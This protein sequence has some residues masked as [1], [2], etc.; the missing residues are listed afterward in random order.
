MTEY[1]QIFSTVDSDAAAGRIAAELVERRLAACVQIVP[2]LRSV[3]WWQGKVEEAEEY[4]LLIKS[5]E[6][7]YPALEAAVRELHPYA[8]PELVGLK[9]AAGLPAY[10]DW[11]GNEV[12]E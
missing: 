7:Q 6:K 5:T 11:L 10:L 9:I 8:C 4:L 1:L 2:K 12:R 3:Y